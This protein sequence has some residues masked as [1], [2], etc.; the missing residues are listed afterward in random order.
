MGNE[1]AMFSTAAI[2][3]VAISSGHCIEKIEVYSH[4]FISH[5]K[6]LLYLAF[7]FDMQYTRVQ[8][9]PD[10]FAIFPSIP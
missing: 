9:K 10:F 8:C 1:V 3:K 2:S 5:L 4:T 7:G 6:I